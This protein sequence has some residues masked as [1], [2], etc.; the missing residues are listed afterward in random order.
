ML[1]VDRVA[2]AL[3]RA[4]RGVGS[5]AVLSVSLDRFRSVND[6]FGHGAGDEVLVAVGERLRGEL[7]V[8]DSV[9]RVGG[10]SF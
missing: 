7:R 8:G 5:V 1:F 2:V 9:A 10:M 4:L 3:K 6:G